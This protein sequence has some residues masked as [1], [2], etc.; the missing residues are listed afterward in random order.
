[1]KLILEEIKN[2][3]SHNHNPELSPWYL[4]AAGVLDDREERVLPWASPGLALAPVWYLLP[5]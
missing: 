5:G 2:S 3:T 4:V 1:L